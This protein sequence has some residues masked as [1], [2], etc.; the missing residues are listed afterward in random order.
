MPE[1]KKELSQLEKLNIRLC[2]KA[3]TKATKVCYLKYN[4]PGKKELLM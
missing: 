1:V 3:M 4:L 2:K